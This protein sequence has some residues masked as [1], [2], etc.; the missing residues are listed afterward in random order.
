MLS[1]A[2]K[3]KWRWA[4]HV[5]RQ[6]DGCRTKEVTDWYPRGGRRRRGRQKT[7]WMDDIASLA[8]NNWISA[9]QERAQMETSCGDLHPSV[10]RQRL[11]KKE[12]VQAVRQMIVQILDKKNC[13]NGYTEKLIYFHI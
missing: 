10:D 1:E 9:A 5:V 7:R 13:C 3:Q 12:E 4:G 8:G 11:K 2:A 6:R